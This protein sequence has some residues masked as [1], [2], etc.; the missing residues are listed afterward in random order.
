MHNMHEGYWV[1]VGDVAVRAE[2]IV[3]KLLE[4]VCMLM[5]L[6]MMSYLKHTQP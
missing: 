1:L 6:G 3:Q 5:M 4:R 2:Q